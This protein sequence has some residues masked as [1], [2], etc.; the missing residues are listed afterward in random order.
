MVGGIDAGGLNTTLALH[1]CTLEAIQ[2]DFAISVRNT[3]VFSNNPE[4]QA[5]EAYKREV[6][7]PI[8]LANL[9]SRPTRAG[10][11]LYA[12]DQWFVTVKQTLAA[13]S[14]ST[15]LTEAFPWPAPEGSPTAFDAVI[16]ADPPQEAREPA[17]APRAPTNS[18]DDLPEIATAGNR[19]TR[20]IVRG[21]GQDQG[22]AT[23]AVAGIAAGV[24][25]LVAAVMVLLL[26]FRKRGQSPGNTTGTRHNVPMG[27]ASELAA[28][29]LGPGMG[30]SPQHD[31]R[32]RPPPSHYTQGTHG[33]QWGPK[34]IG[35]AVPG[36]PHSHRPAL[37]AAMGSDP[38]LMASATLTATAT[39]ITNLTW[40]DYQKATHAA[41]SQIEALEVALEAMCNMHEMLLGR[42]LP[43]SAAHRRVG[44]QGVVQFATIA[45]SQDQAAIKFYLDK[46]AFERERELYT[47]SQLKAMM[48]ATLAVEDNACGNC[49]APYGYTFPPFVIIERGQ[50]L[51]EWAQDNANKDFITIFQ[52][53]SHAVRALSR[54]H[55]F[56]FVHRDIKPGNILRR[57]KQHDWTLIDFG[58]TSRI[59]L[60]T[61]L[62]Y[63]L[64][65]A[66]PEV[67]HALESGSRTIQADAAV[68]IWAIGIIA[69]EL[70]SEEP[71]FASFNMSAEQ[72]D[73]V[74]QDAIAG[75]APLPWEGGSTEA[76]GRV[77]KLRGMR[78]SVLRCLEQLAQQSHDGR[79]GHYGRTGHDGRTGHAAIM[80]SA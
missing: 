48:P 61:G 41:A 42:Y 13:P 76:R 26:V 71:A 33:H 53:L 35:A 55:E 74:A 25:M 12:T 8:P 70:L 64:K 22:M 31:P 49:K 37:Y 6:R 45:H 20:Q 47:E 10:Q 66:A 27:S 62:S 3:D 16:E 80:P 67:V 24:I 18:V 38:S 57:P 23:G 30:F 52:A 17:P 40:S 21:N 54:L 51:D 14:L 78:R 19:T 15:Y 46:K 28:A 29:E 9:L 36:A 65:Y 39:T 63:S 50:S 68:D 60:T 58:C 7:D 1:N 4:H 77:G 69:F 2:S 43:L 72:S 75:R 56:G 44:G 34:Q 5:V 59:G 73:Q 79:T 11:P 32:S